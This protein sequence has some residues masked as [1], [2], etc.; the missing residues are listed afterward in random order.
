MP[1]DCRFKRSKVDDDIYE[2]WRR[3]KSFDKLALDYGVTTRAVRNI[4][5]RVRK[6]RQGSAA[7]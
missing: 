6:R 3:G 1:K 7:P 4:I 2:A 5:N